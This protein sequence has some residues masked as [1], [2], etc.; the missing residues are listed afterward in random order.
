MKTVLTSMF[1]LIFGAMA[2]ANFETNGKIDSIEMGVV[3]V[4]SPV[5]VDTTAQ[6]EAGTENGLA[7]LYKFQNSRV[8]MALSFA[9]KHSKAKWA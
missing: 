6:I 2:L 9:T 5:G 1:I 8:K 7:R 3:L 4:D